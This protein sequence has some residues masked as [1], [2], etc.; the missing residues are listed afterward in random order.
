MLW[1]HPDFLKLW[2]AQSISVFGS[3][4]SAL[5]IPLL[6]ALVLHASPGQMG[7]LQAVETAPFLLIGLGTRASGGGQQQT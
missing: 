5:A 1:R 2:A 7:I 4:F 6:A 3:Q